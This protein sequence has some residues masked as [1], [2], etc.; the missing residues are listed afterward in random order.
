MPDLN[1]YDLP[2]RVSSL[3]S[4]YGGLDFAVEDVFDAATIWFSENNQPVARISPTTGP[5][6]QLGYIIT[7]NWNDATPVNVLCGGF[8]LPGRLNSWQASLLGAHGRSHRC[9]ATQP[10]G[11]RERARAALIPSHPRNDRRR[12]R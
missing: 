12:R 6:P 7:I 3:F 11:D 2:L 8:P 5:T 1:D 4:G 10:G 9:A